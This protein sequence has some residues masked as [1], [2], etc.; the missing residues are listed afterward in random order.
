MTERLHKPEEWYDYW[1]RCVVGTDPNKNDEAHK[2]IY[3]AFCGGYAKGYYYDK[4]FNH[5][6]NLV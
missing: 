5:D 2:K 3:H 4:G 1:N 6:G